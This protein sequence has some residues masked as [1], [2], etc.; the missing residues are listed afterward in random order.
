LAEKAIFWLSKAAGSDPT[1]SD[2]TGSDAKIPAQVT[3]NI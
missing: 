1:G 2:S 3:Q